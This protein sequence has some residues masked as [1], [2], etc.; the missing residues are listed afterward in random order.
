VTRLQAPQ[1][2]RRLNIP[3]HWHGLAQRRQ[4]RFGHPRL[5][6]KTFSISGL[7]MNARL[8]GSKGHAIT[9]KRDKASSPATRQTTEHSD[10]FARFLQESSDEWQVPIVTNL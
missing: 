3:I 8:P 5:T 2:V 10:F 6:S 1:L 9:G 4:T 7:A